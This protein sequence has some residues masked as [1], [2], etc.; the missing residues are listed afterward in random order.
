METHHNKE[1]SSRDTPQQNKNTKKKYF[2]I[3]E[4]ERQKPHARLREI[5]QYLLSDD[6]EDETCTHAVART[7]IILF[8]FCCSCLSSSYA[9]CCCQFL[10]K[11]EMKTQKVALIQF[12]TWISDD[13]AET[14]RNYKRTY[15]L[16]WSGWARRTYE[17]CVSSLAHRHCAASHTHYAR[18]NERI[19]SKATTNTTKKKKKN[20]K[21]RD[22]K[23][24]SC[25]VQ[26]DTE[27]VAFFFVC[28]C[29]IQCACT[30][31]QRLLKLSSN[32]ICKTC[33]RT[34]SS[35]L[36]AQPLDIG[37]NTLTPKWITTKKKEEKPVFTSAVCACVV[38]CRVCCCSDVETLRAI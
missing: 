17:K 7:H 14:D 4:K 37:T 22:E 36:F 27:N 2:V 16:S 19:R 12:P 5:I 24:K 31:H 20:K 18:K 25:D 9:M 11:N 28:I 10:S 6:D 26:N 23:Q 32:T 35:K 15:E 34:R 3:V 29:D 8:N 13:V 38:V 1:V 33:A 30:G 21:R